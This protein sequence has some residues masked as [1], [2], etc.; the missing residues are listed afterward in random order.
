MSQQT[1]T[2]RQKQ[3][4]GLVPLV[5]RVTPKMHEQVTRSALANEMSAAEVVRS[6]LRFYFSPPRKS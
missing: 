2:P 5:V 3:G 1:R 4:D 6:A